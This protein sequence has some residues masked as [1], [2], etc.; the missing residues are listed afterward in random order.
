MC[1]WK[2]E[3]SIIGDARAL[4]GR[5]CV[6]PPRS[7]ASPGGASVA[8][9]GRPGLLAQVLQRALGDLD[10][11]VIAVPFSYRIDSWKL[12][13]GPGWESSEIGS[14][15]HFLARVG[16]EYIIQKEGY[17]IAPKIMFDIID[18]EVVVVGGVAIGLGF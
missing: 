1:E 5:L 16:V 15:K 18:G 10:F 3:P 12:F 14:G 7:R 11:T 4:A 13:A 8:A 2:L 9:G 6:R 17:E